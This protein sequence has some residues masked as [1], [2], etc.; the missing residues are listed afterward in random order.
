MAQ[1]LRALLFRA[2]TP[3][4]S[5]DEAESSSFGDLSRKS[6]SGYSSHRRNNDR[7]S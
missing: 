6:S 2:P 3:T 1:L 7:K 4:H 5:T